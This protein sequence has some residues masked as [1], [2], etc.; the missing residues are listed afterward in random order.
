MRELLQMQEISKWKERKR[1][2]YIGDTKGRYLIQDFY[3]DIE[4]AWYVTCSSRDSTNMI[5]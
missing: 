2:E 3:V 4:K 5:L 1:K